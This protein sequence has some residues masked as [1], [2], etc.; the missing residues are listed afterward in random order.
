MPLDK[1]T[2]PR[3]EHAPCGRQVRQSFECW[4]WNRRSLQKVVSKTEG[5]SRRSVSLIGLSNAYLSAIGA[6]IADFK[7]VLRLARRYDETGIEEGW[8][9]G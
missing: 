2:R 7:A 9:K 3:G 1:C 4:G 6:H 8:N 5:P